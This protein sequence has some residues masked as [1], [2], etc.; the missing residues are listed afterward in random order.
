MENDFVILGKTKFGMQKQIDCSKV[1]EDF[2][3]TCKIFNEYIV[4]VMNKDFYIE[5]SYEKDKFIL[6]AM[7]SNK[8]W[9]F[10]T[11]LDPK[12]DTVSVLYPKSYSEWT[13]RNLLY[14]PIKEITDLTHKSDTF[15]R[16]LPIRELFV[17]EAFD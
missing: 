6:D 13:P 11:I 16:I 14:L 5:P 1:N 17:T 15:I 3:N 8:A 2:K 10:K 4:D 9:D 7:I 12:T